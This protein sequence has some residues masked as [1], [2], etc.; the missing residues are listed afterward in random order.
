MGRERLNPSFQMPLLHDS[1][2]FL[3]SL[4]LGL[5]GAAARARFR[6][7]AHPSLIVAISL[8]KCSEPSTRSRTRS[9]ITLGASR[10]IRR[11]L[12]HDEVAR[13]LAKI[14][15]RKRDELGPRQEQE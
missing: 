6:F 9:L 7:P 3:A 4:R 15:Y 14:G 2:R 13:A 12:R 5:G 1:S 8:R 11:C 10:S